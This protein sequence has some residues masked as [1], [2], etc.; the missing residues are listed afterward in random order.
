MYY[1]SHRVPGRLSRNA[2]G[3]AHHLRRIVW[4][5]QFLESSGWAH[6][7]SS[8]RLTGLYW[9]NHVVRLVASSIVIPHLKIKPLQVHCVLFCV[10]Q[11][12]GYSLL[13]DFATYFF[14]ATKKRVKA[15][16]RGSKYFIILFTFEIYYFQLTQNCQYNCFKNICSP[17]STKFILL[18]HPLSTSDT[19]QHDHF[20]LE[21][22][23][24]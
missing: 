22:L 9:L 19:D 12:T 14:Q 24:H 23:W 7:L 3:L 5:A 1:F 20:N 8:C 13:P 15:V 21:E 4:E 18:F 16:T 2:Q 6:S 17:T 10:E 11:R